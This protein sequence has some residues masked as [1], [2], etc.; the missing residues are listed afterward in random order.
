MRHMQAVM[1][2]G[3]GSGVMLKI[4]TKLATPQTIKKHIITNEC[5][6]NPF[7]QNH[8]NLN[9]T[10]KNQKKQTTVAPNTLLHQNTYIR[11]SVLSNKKD[12]PKMTT[13]QCNRLRGWSCL[14][15]VRDGERTKDHENSA[16][17]TKSR[18]HEQQYC[19]RHMPAAMVHG[20]G[21]GVLLIM[22]TKLASKQTIKKHKKTNECNQSTLLY[23]HIK[24]KAPTQTHKQKNNHGNRHP[25][26]SHKLTPELQNF[27]MRKMD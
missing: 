20:R 24:L 10:T 17:H 23:N 14:Q 16:R 7:P 19:M 26:P 22:M 5:N 1:V 15:C 27:Q 25:A 6:Q 18:K 8:I 13:A 3:G 11:D 21:G 2:H 4:M 9:E 12:G